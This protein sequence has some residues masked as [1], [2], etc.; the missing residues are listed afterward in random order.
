MRGVRPHLR[1]LSPEPEVAWKRAHR[2]IWTR[3]TLMMGEAVWLF[4]SA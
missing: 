3:A 2:P 4:A 1:M